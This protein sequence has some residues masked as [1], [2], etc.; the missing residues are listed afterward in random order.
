MWYQ[1]QDW[2]A[3][4]NRHNNTETIKDQRNSSLCDEITDNIF[5]CDNLEDKH[6]PKEL[7]D[8]SKISGNNAENI[9]WFP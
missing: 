1:F 4:R 9:I 8:L 3:D 2:A 5:V 6:V 7:V